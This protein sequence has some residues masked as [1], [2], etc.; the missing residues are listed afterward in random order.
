M[1][2]SALAHWRWRSYPIAQSPT[3]H[4]IARIG[5]A[6]PL[7]LAL[8]AVAFRVLVRFH[9]YQRCC[10]LWP[11]AQPQQSLIFCL[12]LL[13][14]WSFSIHHG[15]PRWKMNDSHRP[16]LARAN[17]PIT[18]SAKGLRPGMR[19]AL[20]WQRRCRLFLG[21]FRLLWQ[22]FLVHNVALFH[23]N[24]PASLLA[25]LPLVAGLPGKTVAS[26]A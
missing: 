10:L 8:G 14:H 1:S 18:L 15:W 7:A 12:G 11:K 26:D 25:L 5:Q 21:W 19:A 9:H 2:L 16:S 4:Q 13:C 6:S 17:Y 20:R 22:Q 24:C 3:F 23:Q